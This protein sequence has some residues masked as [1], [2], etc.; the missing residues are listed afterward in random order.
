MQIII[1][2]RMWIE[3]TVFD[4]FGTILLTFEI[5]YYSSSNLIRAIVHNDGPRQD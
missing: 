5:V 3:V 2:C 4:Y 1:L